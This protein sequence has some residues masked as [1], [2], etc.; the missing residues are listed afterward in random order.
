MPNVTAFS[1]FCSLLFY[2]IGYSKTLLIKNEVVHKINNVDYSLQVSL[3]TGCFVIASFFAV[4]GSVFFFYLKNNREQGEIM[5]HIKAGRRLEAKRGIVNI[6][7][8][9]PQLDYGL[10]LNRRLSS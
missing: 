9:K 5:L 1:Y 3:A 2:G 7:E 10:D 6:S 8:V 4:I